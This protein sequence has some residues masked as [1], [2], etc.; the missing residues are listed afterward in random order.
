M[1]LLEQGI[2][3]TNLYATGTRSVRGIE[4]VM[5]GFTPTPARSVVKLP[6]AQTGF[7]TIAEVLRQNGY[8]NS[9][10]YGGEAHFD[11]M[12]QFLVGNGIE[13]VH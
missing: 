2:A 10:I 3:F 7:F 12:R 6:K 5:T 9:F 11:N 13:S 1:P 8:A 4:A